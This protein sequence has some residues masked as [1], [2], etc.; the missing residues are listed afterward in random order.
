MKI[1]RR[2]TTR[3]KVIIKLTNNEG[4]ISYNNKDIKKVDNCFYQNVYNLE[5]EPDIEPEKR[6]KKITNV[7]SEE[8]PHITEKGV[9]I[10]LIQGMKSGK[11]PN[12]NEII[13]EML[14]QKAEY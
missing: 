13:P 12:E 9:E 6:D 14:K 4:I 8:L 1:F 3:K 10:M 7:N 5:I 11:A 2:T